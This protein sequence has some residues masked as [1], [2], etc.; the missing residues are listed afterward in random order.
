MVTPGAGYVVGIVTE[1]LTS[2]PDNMRLV[3]DG[4]PSLRNTPAIHLY[5]EIQKRVVVRPESPQPCHLCL[6]SCT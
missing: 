6:L 5:R 4:P 3:S 2:G 1:A